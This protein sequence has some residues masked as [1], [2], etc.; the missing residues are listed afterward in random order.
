M[1]IGSGSTSD[2]TRHPSAE[3][4]ASVRRAIEH[5]LRQESTDEELRRALKA[6]ARDAHARSLRAEEL[7]I[8]LKQMIGSLPEVQRIANRRQRDE[9]VAE[10]VTLCIDVYYERD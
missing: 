10:L 8:V 3:A 9:L 6:L 7:I 2:E 5:H 4:T 1:S